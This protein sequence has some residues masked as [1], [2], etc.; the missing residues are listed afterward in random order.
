MGR[1]RRSIDDLGWSGAV[2][3]PTKRATAV[4][5]RCQDSVGVD[6]K[7]SDLQDSGFDGG[8]SR[9][10]EGLRERSC[11]RGRGVGSAKN[12]PKEKKLSLRKSAS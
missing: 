3:I 11:G 4:V 9:G 12:R 7:V 5:D 10:S 2:A 1:G 8:G 6:I